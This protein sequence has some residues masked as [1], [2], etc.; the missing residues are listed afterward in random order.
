MLL[1]CASGFDWV[2]IYMKLMRELEIGLGEC[3][4][5][6]VYVLKRNRPLTLGSEENIN[7]YAF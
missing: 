7:K 5:P 1:I 4:V 6:E 2:T 3:E